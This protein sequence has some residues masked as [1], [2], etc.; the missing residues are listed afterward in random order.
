MRIKAFFDQIITKAIRNSN[1]EVI[2]HE[3]TTH[4]FTFGSV[5][6]A[7]SGGFYINTEELHKMIGVPTES[8]KI[9][10]RSLE[11]EINIFVKGNAMADEPKNA[12]DKTGEQEEDHY[13]R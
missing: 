10:A 1:G 4:H 7:L 9:T 3:P 5:G 8:K 2:G 12:N 11:V 6:D 13:E